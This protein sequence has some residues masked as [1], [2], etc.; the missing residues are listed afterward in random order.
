M[1]AILQKVG[2]WYAQGCDQCLPKLYRCKPCPQILASKTWSPEGEWKSWTI[3][4]NHPHLPSSQNQ[5]RSSWLCSG[6]QCKLL[7]PSVS[8]SL[9][10]FGALHTQALSHATSEP[11]P[12][13]S[14]QALIADPAFTATHLPNS[15][16]MKGVKWQDTECREL[17]A[18]VSSADIFLVVLRS[19]ASKWHHAEWLNTC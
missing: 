19:S 13:S 17:A 3:C 4:T 2:P 15:P 5:M 14:A 12:I 9:T 7:A 8:Y 10:L 11:S 18:E 16:K 6:V 1:V